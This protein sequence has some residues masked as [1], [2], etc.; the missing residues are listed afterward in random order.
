MN[1][2]QQFQA[3]Q[4]KLPLIAILRGLTP[5]EAVPVGAALQSAGFGLWEVPLNSPEPLQSIAAM[6]EAYPDVLVGAGTV[7]TPQ[8]VRDVH[9]AGGQLIISPNCTRR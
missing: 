9:A 3:L 7:L 5:S 2:I 8:Q 6:R 4:A 1:L